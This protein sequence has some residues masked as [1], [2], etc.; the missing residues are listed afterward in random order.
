[1]KRFANLCI[2]QFVT[3]HISIFDH[4]LFTMSFFFLLNIEKKKKIILKDQ[5]IIAVNN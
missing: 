4:F 1:M 3:F 2:L 5:L